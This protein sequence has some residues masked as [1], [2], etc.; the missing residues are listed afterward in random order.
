[1][2]PSAKKNSSLYSG[3]EELVYGTKSISLYPFLATETVVEQFT[4]MEHIYLLSKG[5][6]LTISVYLCFIK[7]CRLPD[8]IF[9]EYTQPGHTRH[10]EKGGLMLV[11]MLTRQNSKF[12][13]MCLC[14]RWSK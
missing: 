7:W 13:M 10:T 2:A 1:M 9:A 6:T 3:F 14:E 8:T 11:K 5:K 12:A 4:A